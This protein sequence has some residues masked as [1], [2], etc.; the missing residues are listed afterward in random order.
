M[1]KNG[2]IVPNSTAVKQFLINVVG[3]GNV[4]T[5]QSETDETEQTAQPVEQDF[6]TQPTE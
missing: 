3:E 4:S 1:E 5:V 6:A 2:E